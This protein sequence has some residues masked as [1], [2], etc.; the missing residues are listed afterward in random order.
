MTTDLRAF[1]AVRFFGALSLDSIKALALDGGYM[2]LATKYA[3]V[4]AENERLRA[5]LARA[6]APAQHAPRRLPS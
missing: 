2:A 3:Q 5:Q 6:A 4:K 1:F